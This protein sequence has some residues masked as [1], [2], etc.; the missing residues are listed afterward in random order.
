LPS[1]SGAP[2]A[3]KREPEL[4]PQQEKQQA[5]SKTSVEPVVA[6]IEHEP[7]VDLQHQIDLHDSLSGHEHTVHSGIF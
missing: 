6:P 3:I 1:G 7:V 2:P 4:A 5:S